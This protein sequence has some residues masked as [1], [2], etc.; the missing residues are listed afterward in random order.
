MILP[1]RTSI[2]KIDH[3][4]RNRMAVKPLGLPGPLEYA[5]LRSGVE[6]THELNQICLAES[7]F[8]SFH[9]LPGNKS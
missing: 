5:F 3:Q 9:L 4:D 2:E 7:L 6:A 1:S 8:S